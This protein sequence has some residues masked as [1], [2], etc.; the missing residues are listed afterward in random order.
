MTPAAVDPRDGVK[1]GLEGC[2]LVIIPGVGT[3]PG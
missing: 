3:R 1:V 2:V